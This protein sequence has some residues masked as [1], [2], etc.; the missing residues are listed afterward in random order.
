MRMLLCICHSTFS[1]SSSSSSS[2]SYARGL[3]SF[4]FPGFSSLARS[5][6]HSFRIGML[7]PNAVAFT[8]L[9]SCPAAPT[10]RPAS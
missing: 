9:A 8:Q 2:S 1:F 7:M 3:F 10:S 4:L 5:R 6:V